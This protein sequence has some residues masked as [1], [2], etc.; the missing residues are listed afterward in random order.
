MTIAAPPAVITDTD[1]IIKHA[2]E[3]TN[4]KQP[5][6]CKTTKL[7]FEEVRRTQ[8]T[9]T[10]I[11]QI[12]D[13]TRKED[14]VLFYISGKHHTYDNE[15]HVTTHLY[16][17]WKRFWNNDLDTWTD[18]LQ[19][20]PLV[21]QNETDKRNNSHLQRNVRF[22]ANTHKKR[23][24]VT[25]ESFTDIENQ[26][27]QFVK[28]FEQ[29]TNDTNVFVG[30]CMMGTASKNRNGLLKLT[31]TMKMPEM[32]QNRIVYYKNITQYR[33]QIENLNVTNVID[34]KWGYLKK[35]IVGTH[36]CRCLRVF[37]VL[38]FVCVERGDCGC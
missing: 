34:T 35:A 20:T 23:I 16:F 28:L 6:L 24:F 11:I 22:T 38:C 29:T 32:L 21:T 31:K 17:N 18:Q 12:V 13:S 33:T 36:C 27:P 3:D 19:G 10:V 2:N 4:D 8:R 37:G 30:I 15:A 5:V 25:L 14:S 26:L 9:N 1:A 7:I